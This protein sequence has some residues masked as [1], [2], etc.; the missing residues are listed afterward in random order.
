ML[1]KW[2]APE[3]MYRGFI[4]Q[5]VDGA[6]SEDG[7]W[8]VRIPNRSGDFAGGFTSFDKAKEVVDNY[9]GDNQ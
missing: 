1:K 2:E 5:Y 8:I 6:L 3:R 4:L 9:L 7:A